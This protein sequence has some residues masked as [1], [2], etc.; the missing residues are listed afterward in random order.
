MHE[1]IICEKP[2]SAEKIAKALSS[3]AKKKV[4]NKKVKYWELTR[5][6]KDITV[7]SGVGH[8]YSLIPKDS[9]YKVSFNL[10]WVPSYEAS[11]SSSFTK[12]YLNAIKKVAKGADSYIHACDYDVEGTLIGYN[13]LRFACG[14][15][16]LNKSSRMKFSTLTKKDIID[17]YENRIDI[18]MHQVDNG[19][20]RHILDYYFGMNISIAL[21][22]TVKK[23]KHRFLK[24]SVGRV[25]TPTLSILVNREK[26]IRDFVPEPYWNLRAILDFENIEIK[27]VDGNIFDKQ[28]AE[29]IFN[30][31]NGKDATVDEITISNSRT[32]PPVPFNLSGLQAE[33]YNVFG[34]SPKRTQVAAQNLYSAGYTSYPRTSS[35]KL[36]ESLGFANIFKQLSA[37][38]EFKQHID[39]LPSKLKPNNGKKEDAAHPPIHPT[40]ILPTSKLSNDEQKIYNLI[41]YRFIAVFFDAA[42]FETMK[43]ILDIEGEKFKFSRRRVTYK[44]WMEHYPFRKIDNEPFPEVDEGDLMSVKE[45]I[46]D[47]KETKPPARYNQASLIKEL[48]KKNLGTKATRA[49]IVDKLYDRKY[50]EGTKIE[51]NPLGEHLIDT[52]NTYCNDLTS[53]E[54][55]R[56]LEVK[57]EDIN[58]DKAT[59]ESVVGEGEKDVKEILVDI[60]K[61][62][63]GIGSKLYEAYQLS[64]IIG[65]CSCGG[66][67]VKRSGRYGKFVGCTNYPDCNV[68]YSLPRNAY[69]IKKTCEKCGLPMIAAGKGKNRREM[70]LDP[71]CGKDASQSKVH[72]PQE[73]GECPKCGKTLLKRSGRFG[74]FVGCSGFPKCNFTCSLDELESKVKKSE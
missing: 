32:K 1:V 30:K 29:D 38:P 59:K 27:H 74:E 37:N 48:E 43:T 14:E 61:N 49:D 26:E 50:I 8:L 4:Y 47:E 51:V 34:F 20:A 58:Q 60:D 22:D 52:L 62:I 64:N 69:V 45:L 12:N 18:D 68:T 53:E 66:K 15:E 56:D 54:L 71:N 16:S 6:S 70:C 21:S 9:K 13:A 57:L 2:S 31:C 44:G 19:I 5:D 67:L 46:K 39:Q 55:T 41:V 40:G 42:K 33:A 35:Q 25:Q 7:V 28:R 10:H 36:P 11:K 72:D 17:A 73:V 23:T 63:E 3:G 24:L 65:E